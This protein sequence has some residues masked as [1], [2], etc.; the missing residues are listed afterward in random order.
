M[1]K[2]KSILLV[3]LLLFSNFVIMSACNS[4]VVRYDLVRFEN[5]PISVDAYYYNYVEFD[6]SNN[7]YKL[8]NKAKQNDIVTRQTGKFFIGTDGFVTITNDAIPSQNYMLYQGEKSYFEGDR[9]C[10]EVYISGYGY[11]KSIYEK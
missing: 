5:F 8:E 2:F 6:Y 11:I 7:T 1:Q 3:V 9:F 10:T 4:N